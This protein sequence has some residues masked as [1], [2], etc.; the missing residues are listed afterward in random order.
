MENLRDTD[1]FAADCKEGNGLA[2]VPTLRASDWR[3]SGLIIRDE[4]LT[5][6]A[7]HG[8]DVR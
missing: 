1:F 4:G 3:C 5:P 7:N 2:A 8:V 6:K